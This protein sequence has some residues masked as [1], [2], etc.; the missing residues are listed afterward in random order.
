VVQTLFIKEIKM[1]GR[2][3]HKRVNRGARYPRY[4]AEENQQ[5]AIKN[6]QP[7][8]PADMA[9]A[10]GSV[11]LDAVSPIWGFPLKVI[12]D[13]YHDIPK[14][15]TS[16]QNCADGLVPIT[17]AAGAA[18]AASPMGGWQA[19]TAALTTLYALDR[20]TPVPRAVVGSAFGLAGGAV[21]AAVAFV[22]SI[23]IAG[24]K[25]GHDLASR[26]T[27]GDLQKRRFGFELK[28]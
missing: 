23:V 26:P 4:L 19:A 13:A 7:A 28:S 16:L 17:A 27:L 14:Y 3:P 10:A 22:P 20:I 15:R 2:G 6:A 18:Y 9:K 21:C 25:F 1:S 11:V 5:R 12:S 24:I 8:T